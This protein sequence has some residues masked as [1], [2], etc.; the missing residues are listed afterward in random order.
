MTN[1]IK[2]FFNGSR[3]VINRTKNNKNKNLKKNE[4]SVKQIISKYT[5]INN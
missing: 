2:N 1:N 3:I 4:I 5:L